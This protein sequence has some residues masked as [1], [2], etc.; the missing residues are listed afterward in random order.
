MRSLWKGP[1]LKE[2]LGR[3]RRR[4]FVIPPEWVGKEIE[5][6]HGKT[7]FQLKLTKKMVGHKLGEFVRTR[8]YPHHKVKK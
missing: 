3:A 4:S 6:S 8:V 2:Q 7:Y 5:V 1:Y